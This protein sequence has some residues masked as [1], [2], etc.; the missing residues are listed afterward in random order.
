MLVQARI[1]R[2]LG[3]WGAW[4]LS[5]PVAGRGVPRYRGQYRGRLGSWDPQDDGFADPPVAQVYRASS[6]LLGLRLGIPK[7]SGAAL[8]PSQQVLRSNAC[9]STLANLPTGPFS[10]S[11]RE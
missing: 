1:L 8:E 6:K 9:P 10:R 2:V 4:P 3:L 7:T 5:V 11:S